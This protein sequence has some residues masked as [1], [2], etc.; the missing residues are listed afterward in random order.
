LNK[1]ARS[2]IF[3]LGFCLEGWVPI[4]FAFKSGVEISTV[5]RSEPKNMICESADPGTEDVI[6]SGPLFIYRVA[7][8]LSNS[9]WYPLNLVSDKECRIYHV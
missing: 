7:C 5:P 6:S 9:Q 1:Y 4:S 8:P 3:I 2:I